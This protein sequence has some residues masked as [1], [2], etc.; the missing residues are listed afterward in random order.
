MWYYILNLRFPTYLT[1]C[2][3]DKQCDVTDQFYLLFQDFIVLCTIWKYVPD[4]L[5]LLIFIFFFKLLSHSG[6]TELLSVYTVTELM[7]LFVTVGH[8]MPEQIEIF[9]MLFAILESYVFDVIDMLW[10]FQTC[11]FITRT[12]HYNKWTF[13]FYISYVYMLLLN[14]IY[15]GATTVFT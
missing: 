10:N 11:W 5:V 12:P 14:W 15:F 6:C 7:P 4:F 3:N 13:S 8:W 2:M 1:V 9:Q